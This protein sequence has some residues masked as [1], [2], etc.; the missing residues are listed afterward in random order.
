MTVNVEAVELPEF[1]EI[2]CH[3]ALIALTRKCFRA[4]KIEFFYS[5]V[6]RHRTVGCVRRAITAV[7]QRRWWATVFKNGRSPPEQCCIGKNRPTDAWK[8]G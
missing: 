4:A 5:L 6:M 3:N 7:A 1:F 2:K 8:I